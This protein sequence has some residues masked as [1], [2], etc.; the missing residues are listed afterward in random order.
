MKLKKLILILIFSLNL[1]GCKKEEN[2][3]NEF[4]VSETIAVSTFKVVQSESRV[5][6]KSTG[7]LTTENEAKYG[8][9]IGGVIDRI[10]V[11]EGEY[12]KKGKLLATLKT[13]EIDAGFEQAKL[14]LEKAERDL[15]R[16]SNL[17]KDSVATLEQFQNTKTAFEISQKQLES[18]AFDKKYAFIYATSDGFVTKKIANEGEIVGSGVPVLAINENKNNEWILKVGL[19]DK[20]WAMVETGNSAQIFFD[21][22]PDEIF[23]GVVSRKSLAADIGTGSFQVEVK[24]NSKNTIPAIGMFG[25]AV[26]ETNAIQKYNLIPYDALIEADG[27]SAFVFV[28]LPGGKVKRQAIE[29]SNF[30]NYGVQVKSGLIGIDEIVLTNSPFLNE[31]SK[32]T[33]I[34]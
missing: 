15:R 11:N 16:L 2:S 14:G 4:N 6:I 27:K 3:E 18:V 21:S 31:S 32:I 1:L 30:D 12:F 9:K 7:M 25:K 29:I 10:L 19:S 23:D 34:K 24:I 22:F 17:Y 26:I 33:I 5:K 20:D 13:E 8:F 28:P